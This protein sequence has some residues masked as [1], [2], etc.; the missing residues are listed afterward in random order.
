M[1]IIAGAILAAGAAAGLGSQARDKPADAA[2]ACVHHPMKDTRIIDE[3]T[4]GVSD[5]HGHVAIL[6]LS[7]PC[8]RGN[9]QALMVELKD[10]TYQLC[11][12]NDADVV[13]VDGPV[14]LTCRVTDVKLMSREEAE[15]FAP[16]QG[17][18]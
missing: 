13:D 4:V 11:G 18:W 2:P 14:R 3:R 5:H 6:S 12:P 1:M 7:G 8:A 10:M 17:P 15:S 9:P 16:D